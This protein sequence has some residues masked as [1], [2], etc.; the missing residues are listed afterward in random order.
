MKWFKCIFIVA[1]LLM[2]A[3]AW[4]KPSD[5]WLIVVN[6]DA[7]IE[8]LSKKQVISLFL[9]RT[10]FLPSGEK[11]QA[12]DFPIESSSRASFYHALTGKNI[13]DID[14]YWARLKYS[15]KAS[16]PTPVDTDEQII[17]LVGSVPAAIA[18][19]PVE[20]EEDLQQMGLKTVLSMSAE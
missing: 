5:G 12:L 1:S 17:A 6:A 20:H 14:A 16:P 19:L 7:D 4:S 2:S 9:G 15:G 11:A 10:K 8:Q 3:A 18:Y 13:A